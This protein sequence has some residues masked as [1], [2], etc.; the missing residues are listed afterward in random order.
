MSP[1]EPCRIVRLQSVFHPRRLLICDSN[2]SPFRYLDNRYVGTTRHVRLVSG[3]CR[4]T[5]LDRRRGVANTGRHPVP[6]KKKIRIARAGVVNRGAVFP[7][8]YCNVK[9]VLR[10]PGS[11]PCRRRD[12]QTLP[13]LAGMQRVDRR[14]QLQGDTGTPKA[15][16][17]RPSTSL[18]GNRGL[19]CGA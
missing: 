16:R 6:C 3:G 5:A 18:H 17:A 7:M 12:M 9:P 14:L 4:S 1:R 11:Q 15:G 2:P 19:H 8:T 13:L 10:T